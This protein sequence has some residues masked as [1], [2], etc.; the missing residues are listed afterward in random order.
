V[1]LSGV[2]G[3][4]GVWNRSGELWDPL[5]GFP[6]F[7]A[8]ISSTGRL[9]LSNSAPYRAAMAFGGQPELFQIRTNGTLWARA[10]PVA[11]WTGLPEGPWSQVGKGTNWVSVWGEG[12]VAI[13]LTADGR[14]WTWGVDLTHMATSDLSTRLQ[15]A[16]NRI[17]SLFGGGPPMMMRGFGAIPVYLREPRP[18]MKLE[19]GSPPEAIAER[20]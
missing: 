6:K 19:R 17:S 2:F 11:Q 10:Y 14:M 16:K 3:G 5:F 18:F 13:G 7:D 12:S 20:R 9:I 8:P 15:I 4:L 1:A